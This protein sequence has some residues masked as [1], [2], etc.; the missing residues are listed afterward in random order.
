MNGSS[1][2]AG[3]GRPPPCRRR[4]A[5]RRPRAPRAARRQGSPGRPRAP[6]RCGRR[7]PAGR[8]APRAAR[9][10]PRGSTA[11]VSSATAYRLLVRT[12]SMVADAADTAGA[13]DRLGARPGRA[14]QHGIR[15]QGHVDDVEGGGAVLVEVGA[16]HQ[17]ADLGGRVQHRLGEQVPDG[18]VEVVAGRAHGRRHRLVADPD[19]ERLL[20]RDRVG[21]VDPVARVDVEPRAAHPRRDPAHAVIQTHARARGRALRGA[22]R[23]G[24][25]RPLTGIR[26]GH[27]RQ[28]RDRPVRRRRRHQR[29]TT[30]APAPG[31]SC[32][33][34]TARAPASRPSPTG[35]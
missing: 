33:W 27:E 17:R 24:R 23:G 19:L 31:R 13:R 21:A 11:T 8:A 29:R 2:L 34:C 1:R 10:A 3:R 15:R 18:Q 20:D 5:G 35:G 30:T 25:R 32:C 4:C 7:P 22:E 12:A 16:V 14:V 6:R 28:P 26:S 9:R